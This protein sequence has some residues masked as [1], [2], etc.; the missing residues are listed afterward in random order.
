MP[1][2]TAYEVSLKGIKEIQIKVEEGNLYTKDGDNWVF[3]CRYPHPK[4]F[5]HK[6]SALQEQR[7]LLWSK[8]EQYE[9]KTEEILQVLKEV[10]KELALERQ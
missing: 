4:I 5:F 6:E 1:I 9:L 3:L 8:L 7:S 10:E 2:N